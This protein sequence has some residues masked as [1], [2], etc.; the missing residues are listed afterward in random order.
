MTRNLCVRSIV[1]G[2]AL[3]LCACGGQIDG[4]GNESDTGT[5][6]EDIIGGTPVTTDPIGTAIVPS[7][8]GC[9]GTILHSRWLLTAGHCV[10]TD[11]SIGGPSAA[12]SS[13]STRLLNG[14]NT[15]TGLALWRHPSFDVALVRLNAAPL[16]ANG[17]T[18]SNR[19]Y[20]GNVVALAHNTLF[21]Q[22][23]GNNA[24]TACSPIFQGTG[25][26]TL[27]S[28]N[29]FISNVDSTGFFN[30]IPTGGQIEW[31]GDS[32]SSLYQPVNGFFRPI[33]VESTGNCTVTPLA[34]TSIGHVRGDFFRAWAQGIIGTAPAAGTPA[35]YERS[36]GISSIAYPH[37]ET[38]RIRELALVSSQWSL[39]DLNSAAG[40]TVLAT[41]EVSAYVRSDGASAVVFRGNDQHV[42]ELAL[43]PIGGGWSAA[44]LTDCGGGLCTP[45]TLVAGGSRPAAYVRSDRVSAVVYR[46]MDN[47][48]REL[49]RNDN[50]S[51]SK[52]DLTA[53]TGAPAAAGDPIGYVR[54]DGI[55][56]VTYKSTSGRVIEIALAGGS[57]WSA[58]DLSGV[59]GA[60]DSGRLVS[61]GPRPY[62]RP[63]GVTAV[64]Y[65]DATK[66][67]Q[68]LSLVNGSWGINSFSGFTGTT[69]NVAVP[70]VRGDGIA[71]V[72]YINTD[73]RIREAALQPT[74]W[75]V[76]DLTAATGAP[77]PLNP[78]NGVG[79]ILNGYVRGDNVTTVVY[80]TPARHVIELSRA[81]GTWNVHDLTNVVGGI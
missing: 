39:G 69:T 79:S 64:I 55:N 15:P 10:A 18:V 71:A 75:T 33:G 57:Q 48:I 11:C 36:D 25:F 50:G 13:V 7:P 52:A 21:T 56:A 5:N 61:F 49:S 3:S 17:Q 81:G 26:G 54:A 68:E 74:G 32:G 60:T 34:V 24:I 4:G 67:I 70:Y 46:S 41:S 47:H 9:T 80:Q 58:G 76:T 53:I 22:G 27:R 31:T 20:P 72:V 51:W 63:D 16:N 29:I 6:A 2:G 78:V 62:T 77:T 66:R 1:F 30:T 45:S 38:N 23:W 73:S 19:L 35:G 65:V 40:S 8:C 43:G 12:P 59:V 42:R 44:M 37:F 28:A 14:S